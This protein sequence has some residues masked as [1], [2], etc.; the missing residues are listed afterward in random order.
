MGFIEN[1]K[2]SNSPPCRGCEER[3]EYGRCHDTCIGYIE[4]KAKESQINQ[5]RVD[6]K[7]TISNISVSG[8]GRCK[9]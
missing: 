8:A 2:P 5:A 9:V 6:Y 7:K 4:F 3:T 1:F